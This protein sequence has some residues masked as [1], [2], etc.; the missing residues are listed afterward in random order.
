MESRV[1]NLLAADV[2]AVH[3]LLGQDTGHVRRRHGGAGHV[4]VDVLAVGSGDAVDAQG[5]D[6]GTRG[7]DGNRLAVVRA[8]LAGAILRAVT[9]RNDALTVGRSELRGVHLTVA[10]SYNHGHALGKREIDGLLVGAGAGQY[11]AQGQVD[12]LCGL[13]VVGDA[14]DVTAS[15]PRDGVGDVGGSS[16]ASTEYTNRLDEG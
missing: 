9:H 8:R 13:L 4:G 3:Q 1:V 5:E 2:C 11:T 12:H 15:R 6:I 14:I 10:G 16:T 7:R